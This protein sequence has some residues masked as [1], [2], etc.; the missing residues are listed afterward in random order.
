MGWGAGPPHL[1]QGLQGEAE[2]GLLRREETTARRRRLENR[3]EWGRGNACSSRQEDSTQSA[4]T[5]GLKA[6]GGVQSG[7]MGTRRDQN[8]PKDTRGARQRPG[9]RN[10][11]AA[12]QGSSD[13]AGR[14]RAWRRSPREDTR[15]HTALS[16]RAAR[17][18]LP[19]PF[20]ESSP[21]EEATWVTGGPEV[22]TQTTQKEKVCCV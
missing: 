7:H 6:A 1:P 19:D 9:E 18:R 10:T 2:Q 12:A 14:G 17:A 13:R 8:K 3:T 20:R 11:H 21:R 22:D 15:G 4:S 5:L 16:A